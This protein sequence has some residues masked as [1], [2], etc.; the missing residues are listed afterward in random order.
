IVNPEQFQERV[1]KGDPP[2]SALGAKHG[3]SESLWYLL[4]RNGGR[5]DLGLHSAL[6]DEGG[7]SRVD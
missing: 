3:P 5:P 4:A 2:D 7:D 6:H 1:L